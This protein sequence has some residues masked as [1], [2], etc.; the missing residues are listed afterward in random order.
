MPSTIVANI[1]NVKKVADHIQK[2]TCIVPEV[3]II[4]GSGLGKLADGIKDKKIIPYKDIPNFPQTS[5]PGH[6]GNLVFGTI[7][8]RNVIVMQGRF[9]MYEGYNKDEIAL[10]I[11]VMKILGVKILMVSNVAGGLNRNLKCGDFVIL[12]DHIYFPGLGLN[13]ILVGP[14][15]EEFGPRFPALSDAYNTE[16][17]KLA[18]DVAKQNSFEDLVHEGVYVMNG[19]PC[20][21]TPAECK[22]LLQLGCDVVGM[23]TIPEVI[24]ARHC[25]I[26][27]FAVSLVTNISVLEV[28][29]QVIANHEEVLETSA[30]RAELMQLWFEKIIAKLPTN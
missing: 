24:I 2:L 25:G 22:M 26:K 18:L 8:G 7:S 3:G 20:Y 4:C 9:H 27:V 12:K 17:R 6:S 11:R 14:N 5:V 16:L 1:D 30:K 21:E 28:D 15:Q 10:P 29:T 23:S 13:N 19:G